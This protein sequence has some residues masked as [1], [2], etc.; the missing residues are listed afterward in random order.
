MRSKE[1]LEQY[2]HV[3]K[4]NSIWKICAP[5]LVP[6][7][8]QVILVDCPRESLRNIVLGL[9][10]NWVQN[11]FDGHGLFC[12]ASGSVLKQ[13]ARVCAGRHLDGQR[14]E[15]YIRGGYGFLHQRYQDS[16]ECHLFI[17]DL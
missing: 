9:D 1:N 3:D 17:E 8:V 14:I 13:I 10:I 6:R 7:V 12:A 4:L 15:K 5:G 11:Y 2:D 16:A